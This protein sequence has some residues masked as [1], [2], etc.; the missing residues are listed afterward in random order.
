MAVARWLKNG[1]AAHERVARTFLLLIIA[2]VI[3]AVA[4]ALVLDAWV[5]GRGRG[6]EA[7]ALA[8]GV[9]GLGCVLCTL[10]A[11]NAT[12]RAAAPTA[13][14]VGACAWVVMGLLGGE[15]LL[16]LPACLLWA[17][18]AVWRHHQG[19]ANAGDLIVAAFVGVCAAWA[20]L[21]LAA[22][23]R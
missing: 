5:P 16:W 8:V 4:P 7:F 19:G 10:R 1:Q 23:F 9:A 20:C 2:A 15:G 6:A 18:L 14:A 11:P 3:A 13:G 21:F 22:P 17:G 12:V